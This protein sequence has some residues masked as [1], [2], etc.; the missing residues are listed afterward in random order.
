MKI[1]TKFEPKDYVWLILDNKVI[2]V[3]I[4]NIFI[5]V[6]N[7]AFSYNITINYIVNIKDNK[8][9]NKFLESE[10]FSTKQD[11]LNSL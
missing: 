8:K 7:T 2:E 11:L 5:Y 4:I 9:K 3:L 10:L 6:E 1:E